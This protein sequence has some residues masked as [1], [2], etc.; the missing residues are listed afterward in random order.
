MRDPPSTLVAN[1]NC[2]SQTHDME[3]LQEGLQMK[4]LPVAPAVSKNLSL[5]TAEEN[6]A[7]QICLSSDQCG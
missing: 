1:K 3:K 2:M 5:A 6:V 7:V 4:K